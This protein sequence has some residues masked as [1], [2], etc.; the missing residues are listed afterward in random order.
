MIPTSI[1]IRNERKYH[2]S[3]VPL[4]QPTALSEEP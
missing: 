3:R 2:A 4:P 1:S